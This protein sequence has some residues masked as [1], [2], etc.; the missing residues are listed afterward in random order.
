MSYSKSPETPK[1][2]E[3]FFFSFSF[4]IFPTQTSQKEISLLS[5]CR[6]HWYHFPSPRAHRNNNA[7]IWGLIMWTLEVLGPVLNYFG[8][9]GKGTSGASLSATPARCVDVYLSASLPVHRCSKKDWQ[10][11]WIHYHI[12]FFGIC[13]IRAC[14]KEL[15]LWSEFNWAKL[16]ENSL[17]R[18][19]SLFCS[20]FLTDLP[21]NTDNMVNLQ[22]TLKWEISA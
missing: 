6:R 17:R 18:V 1:T 4:L 5:R 10:L 13:R 9:F 22:G 21:W 3:I 20:R 11:Y 2:S 8:V 19:P 15:I 16:K 14:P 7:S 12:I